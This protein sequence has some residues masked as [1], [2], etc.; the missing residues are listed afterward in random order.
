VSLSEL[1]VSERVSKGATDQPLLT[2][3][4]ISL[5]MGEVRPM[6][7]RFELKELNI[8]SPMLHARRDQAGTLNLARLIEKMVPSTAT[9]ASQAAPATIK[10][11]A[12]NLEGGQLTWSDSAV[13]PVVQMAVQGIDFSA[14]GLA[15]PAAQAFLFKGQAQMG[16]SHWQWSGESDLT[17][18][19]VQLSLS[20]LPIQAISPYLN[21][22]VTRP[23]S[24]DLSM[25]G[26]VR[27]Q[28]KNAKGDM[29]LEVDIAQLNLDRPTL[30][31]VGQPDAAL[32]QLVVSKLRA[33]LATRELSLGRIHA[34]QPQLEIKRDTQGRWM[35]E[36]WLAARPTEPPPATTP[37][38]APVSASA[39]SKAWDVRLDELWVDRGSARLSDAMA[40][41]DLEVQDFAL[42]LGQVRPTSS[43]PVV[44][45]I[46]SSL[47]LLTTRHDGGQLRVKGQLKLPVPG[48]MP[49][50]L[51]LSARL[52][53]TDLP[54]HAVEPYLNHL[55]N[56][57]LLKAELN[58][59]GDLALQLAPEGLKLRL[60]GDMSID[61]LRAS[62]RSPIEPLLDWKTLQLRG[63]QVEVTQ[64]ALNSLTVAETVLSDFFARIG[65]APDGRINLQDLL[66]GDAA[67]PAQ[68]ADA[69]TPAINFG[70]LRLQ[71]GRVDFS[72]RF[73]QPNYSARLSDLAGSLSAFSNQASS[74]EATPRLADLSLQG[75]AEGSATLA[76][77]GKLNPLARP[78]ALDVRAQAKDLELPPLSPYSSKYAGYGIERG[79]LSLDVNYRVEPS[80]QLTASNQIV[81]NQLTFG[82]RIEGSQAPS[83]PL[84]LAVALLSDSQGMIDINV[85]ISGSINEPQFRLWPIIG[86]VIANLVTKAITAPFA[87]LSGGAADKEAQQVDFAP[88][89]PELS[90]QATA[91]LNKLA[92]ALRDRPALRLTVEGQSDLNS[93]AGD[94]R[95]RKLHAQVEAE[96]RRQAISAGKAGPEVT[97]VTP[98]EYT[99]LLKEVYRRS[100]IR[101]PRN[102]VGLT[103]D[104]PQ[105]EMEALLLAAIKVD[106]SH[107]RELALARGVAVKD[108]L[109]SQKVAVERLFLGGSQSKGSLALLK[110]ST[111]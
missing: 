109:A 82:E 5:S 58:Y 86:R 35:Y 14:T 24:G 53:A 76:V 61:D 19:Q 7:R 1:A 23:L 27:W 45:P 38:P 65:V 30:G 108:Y 2:V 67:A 89:S 98:A 31:A 40:G 111:Q 99:A 36:N 42:R 104:L 54:V 80:G 52:D 15:S 94:W 93:E 47:R 34:I 44:T 33:N 107:M 9:Q 26:Q 110:L 63:V 37:A 32:R 39:G 50:P 103:K 17:S 51:A 70:P 105:A 10:L 25:Q 64:G 6:E 100:D 59:G 12:F 41:A 13:H 97:P 56:F 16:K 57:E 85:P 92:S 74:T 106:D 20:T 73:I 18:A 78:L 46:E 48:P 8:L 84:K 4:R 49:Q 81:L 72:D 88:G 77:Q 43:R 21:D 95:L 60:T 29:G 87:L 28:A 101:K 91:Q 102:M 90:E 11:D 62:T 79:K 66:R 3:Q 83:L 55:L 22:V 75:R 68:A 69:S 96:K 71:Q